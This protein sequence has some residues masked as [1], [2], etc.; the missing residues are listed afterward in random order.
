LRAVFFGARLT[1]QLEMRE[2]K[3]IGEFLM[4]KAPKFLID[5]PTFDQLHIP[6]MKK[7]LLGYARV[8]YGKDR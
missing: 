1:Y 4:S 6:E 7:D 3:A 8:A 5:T 2:G